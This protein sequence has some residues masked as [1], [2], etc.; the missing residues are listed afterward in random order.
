MDLTPIIDE[1]RIALKQI[2]Y[3]KAPGLDGIPVE[4]LQH[5]G[6]N[7]LSSIHNMFTLS[8]KETP[9]PQDWVDGILVSIFKGKESKSE[10]DHSRNITLL[11][12]VGK[13]LARLL[14]DRLM[15]YICPKVIPETQC[16]FRSG[17]G[18]A[19]MIY[20]ARQIQEKCIE[21]QIPLYQVFV[22]LTK[23]FDT[24]NR[25]AL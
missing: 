17:R 7:K 24:V 3:V 2:N 16:G 11:E 9:I 19:D 15:E 21:Q 4:L 13:V 23:A 25:E 12:A 14:L 8:W 5:G 20:S 10:C 22:D 6:E 1:V 18:A